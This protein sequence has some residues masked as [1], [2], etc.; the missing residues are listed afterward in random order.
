MQILAYYKYMYMLPYTVQ[1][2][3]QFAV[4]IYS[5]TQ[6]VYLKKYMQYTYEK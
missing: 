4:S 3:E 2:W 1:G 5:L 6:W